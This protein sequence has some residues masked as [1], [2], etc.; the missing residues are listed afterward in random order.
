MFL[1]HFRDRGSVEPR[2]SSGPLGAKGLTG[3]P[4]DERDLDC[5]NGSNPM[6]LTP[7]WRVKCRVGAPSTKEETCQY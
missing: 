1:N 5:W 6:R 3:G 2:L 7:N 4:Y